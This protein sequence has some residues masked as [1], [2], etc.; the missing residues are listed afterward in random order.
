MTTFGILQKAKTKQPSAETQRIMTRNS[1]EIILLTNAAAAVAAAA[2]NKLLAIHHVDLNVDF[3]LLQ[4][5]LWGP[6]AGA[7]NSVCACV[8][9]VSPCRT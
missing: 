1:Y 7:L 8:S 9:P 6:L 2:L 3:H 4:C 5:F